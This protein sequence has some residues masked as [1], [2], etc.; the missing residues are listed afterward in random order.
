LSKVA[1]YFWDSCVF[2]RYLE[3]KRDAPLLLDI[4]QHIAD[5][6]AGKTQIYFSTIAMAEIRPSHLTQSGYGDFNDFMKDFQGSF[7]PIGPTPD[8]MSQVASIRDFKYPSPFSGNGDRILGIA[9]AIHLM[10]CVYARNVLGIADIE[11][12]TFDEGKGSNWEGK[13]VPLIK[14]EEWTAGIP[15]NPYVHQ[16]CALT[17]RKP[18]HDSPQM[19]L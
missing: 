7:L 12:H 4:G 8:I 11:F 19:T 10:T 18:T 6:K 14:F 16:I 2:I 9:D 15:S 13:C 3:S 1:H 5:V 17:R